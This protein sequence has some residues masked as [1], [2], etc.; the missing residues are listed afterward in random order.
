[1]PTDM[2]EII[3]EEY[4]QQSTRAGSR[5]PYSGKNPC[6]PEGRKRTVEEENRETCKRK[7]K[8]VEP[9]K[10]TVMTIL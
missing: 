3:S 9:I 8:A 5:S 7:C 1:M 4:V 10:P 2:N 6:K